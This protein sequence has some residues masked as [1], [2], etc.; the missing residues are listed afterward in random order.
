MSEA[1][2]Q[3]ALERFHALQARAA[4]S[5]M[6]EP[7][8][9]TLATVGANGRPSSRV[10]LLKGA[11][12]QGF[13]FYTNLGSRKAAE[14]A[15]NANVALCFFWPPLMEQV[16]VEGVASP[17]GTAEAD[18]YWASRSADSQIGAW[19]SRQSET[20]ASRALLE[21]RV[22]RFASRFAQGEVPRPEF[23]SGYRVRPD[24]IEFWRSLPHRLHER[25]CYRRSG[26]QWSSE[27]L[28]P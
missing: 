5:G 18:A 6:N 8:A 13:V 25:V 11:D 24:R 26:A 28:Y 1:L 14:L 3:E 27:L 20:L 2:Y 7:T 22:E 19:A 23:W 10:V 17:V 16:R 4:A 15:A 12:E 9:F 21:E